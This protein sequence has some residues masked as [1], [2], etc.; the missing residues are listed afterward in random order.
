MNG[1]SLS[2]LGQVFQSLEADE[3]LVSATKLAA[4]RTR[5]SIAVMVPLIWLE[6]QLDKQATVCNECVPD[7]P[8]IDGVPMYAY[9]KHTRLGLAAMQRLTQESDHIR[10]CLEKFVPKPAWLK[11][12]QMA[13][14]Y[15]D[16]Y[17]VSR[18]LEWSLSRSIEELGI[19]SDF[20]RIG[21]PPEAVSPLREALGS[22]TGRMNCIRQELSRDG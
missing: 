1:G 16:G 15:T 14:F 6:A 19:E 12:V 21:V 9:D 18:R 7:C 3:D 17:L 20:Y 11:A 22:E 5:E 4:K 8:A 13:A 10:N 2:Q